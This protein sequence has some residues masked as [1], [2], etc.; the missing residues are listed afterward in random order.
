MSLW[1]EDAVVC[2]S[3][4]AWHLA[5]TKSSTH[6]GWLDSCQILGVGTHIWRC[7]ME[8]IPYL[9]WISKEWPHYTCS[10]IFVALSLGEIPSCL[11]CFFLHKLF[12]LLE[13]ARFLAPIS[14][15][16]IHLSSFTS[17]GFPG[18]LIWS[19]STLVS[20]GFAQ[21]TKVP[22]ALLCWMGSWLDSL[23]VLW[24]QELCFFS[25]VYST[26]NIMGVIWRTVSEYLWNESMSK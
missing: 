4:N 15:L 20:T 11:Y 13:G 1:K 6:A 2:S 25:F 12:L 16:P 3:L 8:F 21:T 19:S 26:S 17:E 23:G 22:V 24:G 9:I 5:H 10:E 7:G 14:I 18:P